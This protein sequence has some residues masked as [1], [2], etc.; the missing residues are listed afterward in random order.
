MTVIG[1][2]P[3]VRS[4]R[5]G[6]LTKRLLRDALDSF[7][8]EDGEEFLIVHPD[9]LDPEMDDIG[10]W[11]S[12][13]PNTSIAAALFN[14][15]RVGTQRWRVLWE[16]VAAGSDGRT[17]DELVVKLS[18]YSAQRRLHDLKRGGWVTGT[19]RTRATRR[20]AQAEVYVAS[21]KLLAYL[22]QEGG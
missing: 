21:E 15:P 14:Y 18:M 6:E 17:S 3:R 22:Q 7:E 1:H 9:V 8:I 5:R 11:H 19:G 10:W 20:G 4:F 16:I 2:A 13:D 12:D